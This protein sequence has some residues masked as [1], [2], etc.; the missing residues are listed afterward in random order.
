MLAKCPWTA[1]L[2]SLRYSLL[3]CKLCLSGYV[4]GSVASK[5][6]IGISFNYN[7]CKIKFLH[8]INTDNLFVRHLFM[9]LDWE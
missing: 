9:A 6:L 2:I 1:K 3:I 5:W 4:K 8:Y 7:Y